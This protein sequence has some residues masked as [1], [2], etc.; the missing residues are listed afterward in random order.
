MLLLGNVFAVSFGGS[1]G[2]RAS[3]DGFQLCDS[4]RLLYLSEPWNS[5]SEPKAMTPIGVSEET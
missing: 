2:L 3:Q 4:G 5:P 1:S